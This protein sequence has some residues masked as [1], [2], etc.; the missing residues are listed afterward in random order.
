MPARATFRPR[1]TARG[2]RCEG[3]A[4][5]TLRSLGR[6]P[7]GRALSEVAPPAVLDLR[8]AAAPIR[9]TNSCDG[10]HVRPRLGRRLARGDAHQGAQRKARTVQ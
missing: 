3:G 5:R 7:R 1:T 4:A 8:T 6:V 9:L 10:R 2:A